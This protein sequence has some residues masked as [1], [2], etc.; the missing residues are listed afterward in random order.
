[1]TFIL[2]A[3]GLEIRPARDAVSDLTLTVLAAAAE[4]ER[5]VIIERTHDGLAPTK[6]GGASSGAH[7]THV[8]RSTRVS[9][10]CARRVPPG[11]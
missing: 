1:M 8:G 5:A 4:F 11:T 2:V 7:A 3:Q 6:R 9:Q 10:S